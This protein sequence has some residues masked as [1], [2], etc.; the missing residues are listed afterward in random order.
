MK[1]VLTIFSL[2]I[3]LSFHTLSQESNQAREIPERLREIKN[4][5]TD[6]LQRLT[7]K[8][9]FLSKFENSG[10]QTT[11]RNIERIFFEQDR[12]DTKETRIT[13]IKTLLDN[14][15]ML[16]ENINQNWDGFAWVNTSK[17]D[18]ACDQSNN[19]IERILQ[20]W[21]GLDWSNDFKHNYSYDYNNNLI[22]DIQQ[23]WIGL[24]ENSYKSIYSY[25]SNNNKIERVLQKWS[26]YEW[27]NL[28]RSLISYSLNN[29]IIEQLFQNWDVNHWQDYELYNYIYNEENKIKEV[30]KKTWSG[31][32]WLNKSLQK[33]IYNSSSQLIELTCPQKSDPIIKLG[34]KEKKIW[35]KSDSQASRS[36]VNFGKQR[37]CNQMVKA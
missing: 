24:W 4:Q 32:F 14:G 16:I 18:Y 13:I 27:V 22:E 1:S 15:F 28:Q 37:F 29:N 36:S 21:T 19:Q 26:N 7:D 30:Q 34:S 5:N 3:F 6:D 9:C 8:E 33:Q 2:T 11:L 12:F 35:A 20:H 23:D 17:E 10:W 31:S 25:D